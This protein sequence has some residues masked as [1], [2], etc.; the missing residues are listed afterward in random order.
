MNQLRFGDFT[1]DGVTDVLAVVGG[2]WAISESASSPWRMLNSDL[3]D[4]VG[5]LFI[6][7]MD[8]DDNIDDILRL[9]CRPLLTRAPCD[10]ATPGGQPITLTWWRSKNGTQPWRRWK[11]YVFEFY[12]TEDEVIPG[13]GFVGRFGIPGG[14]TLVTDTFRLGHFHFYNEAK[15][16]L[17]DWTS[18]FPY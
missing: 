6:A 18:L 14:G 11:E 4:A 15:R 3:G 13:F 17:L 10:A 5:D 12:G 1:G 9:E 7:N 16:A 8:A 2:R